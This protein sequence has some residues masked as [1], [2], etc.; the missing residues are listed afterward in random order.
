MEP[1]KMNVTEIP[2]VAVMSVPEKIIFLEDLWDSIA[3]HDQAVPVQ[4]SRFAR[5][6]ASPDSLLSLQEL[7]QKIAN[8]T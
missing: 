8:R 1:I 7:Q 5:H 3:I 4:E 6:G 2:Q